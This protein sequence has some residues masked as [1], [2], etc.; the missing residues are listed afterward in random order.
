MR[1]KTKIN[2]KWFKD[3]NVRHDTTQLLEETLSKTFSDI[4]YSNVFLSQSPKATEI[5]AK[6]NKW[7]PIR[8]T[9]FCRAKE[10]INKTKRQPMGWEKLFAND[11]TEKGFNFQ[12]IQTA[13]RTQ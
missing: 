2:S 11:V 1:I 3:L 10:A 4:N 9:S 7:D 12:N 5:K 8:L 6:I 13:H